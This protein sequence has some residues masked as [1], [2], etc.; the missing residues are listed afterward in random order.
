[1]SLLNISLPPNKP[2]KYFPKTKVTNYNEKKI[3]SNPKLKTP[4]L[5]SRVIGSELLHARTLILN[6]QRIS[7][8]FWISLPLK[9]LIFP[10][11]HSCPRAPTPTPTSAPHRRAYFARTIQVFFPKNYFP[12]NPIKKLNLTCLLRA[13]LVQIFRSPQTPPSLPPIH[14]FVIIIHR[15]FPF[16]RTSILLLP[17]ISQA[18]HR[19]RAAE[20]SVAGIFPKIFGWQ[21]GSIGRAFSVVFWGLF[22]VKPRQIF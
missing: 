3:H 21:I 19:R 8:H 14:I 18:A 2:N 12:I 16:H 6:L 9:I 10:K 4:K 15:C 5:I 20:P 1:L 22:W 7:D 13:I 11:L 17:N